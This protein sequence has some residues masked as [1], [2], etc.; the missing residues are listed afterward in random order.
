MAQMHSSFGMNFAE[1]PEVTGAIGYFWKRAQ[2][3]KIRFTLGTHFVCSRD[4]YDFWSFAAF[5][6]QED[7]CC[8]SFHPA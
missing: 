1:F 7:V 8:L 6:R 3:T 5:L 2:I 4:T